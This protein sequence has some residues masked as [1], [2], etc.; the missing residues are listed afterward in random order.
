[1]PEYPRVIWEGVLNGLRQRLVQRRS[2]QFCYEISTSPDAMGV[3]RWK[4]LPED[5]NKLKIAEAA[6]LELLKDRL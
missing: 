2:D 1:M 3:S 4:D 6:L 5:H